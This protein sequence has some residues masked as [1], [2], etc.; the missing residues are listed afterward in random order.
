MAKLQRHADGFHD[1]LTKPRSKFTTFINCNKWWKLLY[2]IPKYGLIYEYCN[3]IK[4]NFTIEN[5][6]IF[7]TSYYEIIQYINKMLDENDL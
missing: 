3:Y 4:H 7:G 5:L 1:F 6:N 2:Q